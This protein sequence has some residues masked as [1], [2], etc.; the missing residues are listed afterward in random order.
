MTM[1][2]PQFSLKTLLWLMALVAAFF[3]GVRLGRQ[4][5]RLEDIE[6]A[7]ADVER[8]AVRAEVMAAEARAEQARAQLEESSEHPILA[9]PASTDA[10][11]AAAETQETQD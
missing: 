2:R 5:Q 10:P 3:G 11:H 7:I 1:S 8:A 9:P 6:A 4:R